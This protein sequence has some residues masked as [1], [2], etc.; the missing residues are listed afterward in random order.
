V[1]TTGSFR[2]AATAG[3]QDGSVGATVDVAAA[4]HG[5]L[6]R[7]DRIGFGRRGVL[8]AQQEIHRFAVGLSNDDHARFRQIV[9][10]WIESTEADRVTSPLHYNLPEHVQAL[11]IRL[12]ASVPI[13]ESLPLLRRLQ[14]A[15]T[16][17]GDDARLC[18]EALRESATHLARSTCR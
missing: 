9:V 18:R 4:L 12:C 13:P 7:Y 5:I 11:A 8:D 15:G 16:F 17:Q 2:A 1:S 14:A 3:G 6:K 10:S